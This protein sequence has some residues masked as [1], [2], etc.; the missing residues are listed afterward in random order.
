MNK[1]TK[2]LPTI[3]SAV[4]V[5]GVVGTAIAAVRATPKAVKILDE[6]RV[7]KGEDLTV[8]EKFKATWKCYLPAVGIGVG[9][10]ACIL[11]ANALN[12]KAQASIASAYA[13]VSSSY[14]KYKGK[15]IEKYGK[16]THDE[17]ISSIK[18]EKAN[19]MPITAGSFV[20]NSC[21]DFDTN[22]EET[23][24]YDDFSQR[25]FTSTI[26][27]V[28]Q[29]EYHLNRNYVLGGGVYVN[30]F[31]DFLGISHVDEGDAE[32]GWSCYDGE[33][34]WIDFNHVKST[35]DDGLEVCIIEMIFEPFDV[36]SDEI[37]SSSDNHYL[38]NINQNL[39]ELKALT[40]KVLD[41]IN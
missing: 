34:Q 31:Y 35:T 24:F 15:V 40:D 5:I 12:R 36:Y 6:R 7:Q 25:Y 1:F 23:L 26:S 4:G 11:G 2:V 29:A 9:T 3:L 32:V 22:E 39:V 16:D 28:L 10:A 19:A 8:K 41:K 14:N 30:D 27:K 33:I 20:H 37:L 38:A 13:L 18:A 17:I 21:L